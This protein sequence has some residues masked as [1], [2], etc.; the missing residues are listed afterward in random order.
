M[1]F[2]IT[3]YLI[4]L[5]RIKKE[6][7]DLAR[8]PPSSCSAGPVGD[9]LFVWKG[10][11]IGPSNSRYSGGVFLLDIYF[12]SDYPANPPRIVFTTRVYH[13]NINTKGE[14]S[15]DILGSNYSPAL[16]IGKVLL[17]IT[18]FLDDPNPDDP[19]MPE[20]AYVYKKDRARYESTA[21][22]WTRKY[23]M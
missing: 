20:I 7:S 3:L 10:T 23:A 4:P 9:N 19:L 16:T 17:S 14:I 15:L 11:I 5:Q 18:S 6:L 1:S 8:D 2:H 12:P 21:R 13:P 22:E